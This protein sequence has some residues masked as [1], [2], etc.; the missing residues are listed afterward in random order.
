M[1]RRF[2]GCWKT[3]KMKTMIEFTTFEEG[4]EL[5]TNA[6]ESFDF[7]HKFNNKNTTVIKITDDF[8]DN[9]VAWLCI[10]KVKKRIFK[11]IVN[12]KFTN[13]IQRIFDNLVIHGRFDYVISNVRVREAFIRD[14]YN[15]GAYTI[16]LNEVAVYLTS[17][18]FISG[19]GPKVHWLQ[20]ANL[21]KNKFHNYFF[22]TKI[23][24]GND[25]LWYNLM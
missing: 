20:P 5:Y 1:M 24:N 4:K 11:R 14:E 21:E 10:S 22:D 16:I 2:V 9:L 15:E 17:K 13:E 19:V 6:T 8:T 18:R 3:Y 25:V 23:S 7:C 12:K